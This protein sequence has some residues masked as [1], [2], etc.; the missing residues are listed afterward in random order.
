MGQYH[1]VANYDKKEFLH[2]HAFGDGL[3]LMEFGASAGG[4]LQGLAILLA[5]SNG[6]SGRGGGDL[7]PWTGGLG[8]EGR[9]V[10]GLSDEDAAIYMQHIV[11]RWA[12]DRIAIIGDYCES[13][14]AQGLVGK[15]GSP[16]DYD[17]DAPE[18]EWVDIS[19]HVIAAMDLDYYTFIDRHSLFVYPHGY[20][21]TK[22]NSFGAGTGKRGLS[23]LN[24]D[25]TI[26]ST[27]TGVDADDDFRPSAELPFC[28]FGYDEEQRMVKD[29][30]VDAKAG[31]LKGFEL[32][33]GQEETLTPKTYSLAKIAG[34]EFDPT[35]VRR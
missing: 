10:P 17:E 20:A 22:A 25:G 5:A 27:N 4:T 21:G 28:I 14:D 3:K 8:Y 30:V 18:G 15:E 35:Q 23:K 34:S 32:R 13:E 33:R 9:E 6:P 29:A 2:P 26:V 1:Y 24:A 19:E 31:T 7:H 12:G 16:W 11:G